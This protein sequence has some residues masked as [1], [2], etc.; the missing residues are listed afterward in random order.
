MQRDSSSLE[1]ATSRLNSQLPIAEKVP[2]ADIVIDNSGS[3]QELDAQVN[4]I[5]HKL[6]SEM[7][8]LWWVGYILP[9]VS[10]FSAIWVLATRYL[11]SKESLRKAV[12]KT[13]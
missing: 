11:S 1:D 6:D 5:I 7:G 12:K 13:D 9:P 8:W 3:P 10:L 4:A 2:Y